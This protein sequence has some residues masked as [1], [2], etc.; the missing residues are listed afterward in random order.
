MKIFGRRL[1]TPSIFKKAEDFIA[2]KSSKRESKVSNLASTEFVK[3]DRDIE[4]ITMKS[5]R[6]LNGVSRVNLVEESMGK[7]RDSTKI[8]MLEV[9]LYGYVIKIHI[10]KDWNGTVQ[11][12]RDQLGKDLKSHMNALFEKENVVQEL[13]ENKKMADSYERVLMTVKSL[14]TEDKAIPQ[15]LSFAVCDF[16]NDH[17]SFVEACLN[18]DHTEDLLKA[19]QKDL[20]VKTK[21]HAVVFDHYA[22]KGDPILDVLSTA[23]NNTQALVEG[24]LRGFPGVSNVRIVNRQMEGLGGNFVTR[25][26]VM[27]VYGFEFQFMIPK[28]LSTLKELLK[29]QI[30]NSFTSFNTRLFADSDVLQN[31][32]KQKNA[33]FVKA[34]RGLMQAVSRIY[35]EDSECP[36]ELRPVVRE[37]CDLGVKLIDLTTRDPQDSQGLKVMILGLM[38]NRAKVLSNKIEQ[39]AGTKDMVLNSVRVIESAIEIVLNQSK[40][41]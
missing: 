36:D 26:A 5:L 4:K 30:A 20:L 21:K 19:M 41:S 32:N 39:I 10:P 17:I 40:R 3:A 6:S 16:V 9:E 38:H 31:I 18:L 33:E 8:K 23:P 24:A 2:K 1:S 37:L 7:G 27:D 14:Y 12:V 29:R 34:F 22:G 25:N 35:V 15:E 28:D 11:S 13:R